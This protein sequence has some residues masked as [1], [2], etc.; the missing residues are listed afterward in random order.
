MIIRVTIA[1]VSPQAAA[2]HFQSHKLNG[3]VSESLG[4]GSWGIEPGITVEFGG[5]I[6]LFDSIR[7]AVLA[8]LHS[9]GEQA[10]YVVVDGIPYLWDTDGQTTNLA[11]ETAIKEAA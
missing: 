7:H 5:G 1:N 11:D 8:L 2:E 9:L 4:F 3:T 10:A 6:S